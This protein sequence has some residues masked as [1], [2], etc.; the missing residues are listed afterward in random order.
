M[1]NSAAILAAETGIRMSRRKRSGPA[2]SM[3]AASTSSSGMATNTWRNS[4]VAAAEA[5][6]GTVSAAEREAEE[7][8]GVGGK[9]RN[10]DLAAGDRERHA[11]GDQQH[12]PHRLGTH[13]ALRQ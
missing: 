3:R 4:S 6:S 11:A 7:H 10:H 5:I 12:V 9:D 13:S 1:T 8:H 2:P